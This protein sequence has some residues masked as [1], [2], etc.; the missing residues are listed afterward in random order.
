MTID[1]FNA[2][3]DRWG[4]VLEAWPEAERSLGESL[5]RESTEARQLHAHANRIDALLAMEHRAPANLQRKIL[6]Q[7]ATEDVW[8]RLADWFANAFWK[9]TL[10]A[11][12]ML[13]VGFAYGLANN[14]DSLAEGDL[15]EVSMLAFFDDYQEIDD[16]L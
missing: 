3:L 4:S 6:D 16:A 7:I 5:L 8:Q 13:V 14:V 15:E 10:A 1:E 11:A 2:N 12:C 9:P